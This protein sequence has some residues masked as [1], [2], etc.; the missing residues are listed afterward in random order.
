[1]VG[2]GVPDRMQQ[3]VL[4]SMKPGWLLVLLIFPKKSNF[5]SRSLYR[6]LGVSL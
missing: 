5:Q 2:A 3:A 6:E 1:M 4:C